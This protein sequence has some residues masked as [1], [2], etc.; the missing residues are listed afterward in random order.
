MCVCVW[1][2]LCSELVCFWMASLVNSSISV[3]HMGRWAQIHTHSESLHI[4]GYI[5]VWCLGRKANKQ[6]EK[7]ENPITNVSSNY[8]NYNI[9]Q[10]WIYCMKKLVSVSH[11][12]ITRADHLT[13]MWVHQ[14][15]WE[16]FSDQSSPQTALLCWDYTT[17]S[18]AG[19]NLLC[20]FLSMD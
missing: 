17:L 14:C 11:H 3:V 8:V 20:M 6:W 7:R 1:T 9:D 10:T 18:K 19:T 16:C 5:C 15:V 4:C 12:H 2:W 13:S